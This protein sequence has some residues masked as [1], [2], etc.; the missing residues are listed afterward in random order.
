MS[1]KSMRNSL[2]VAVL[3][4]IYLAPI[5]LSGQGIRLKADSIAVP[6]HNTDT[7]LMPIRLFDFQNIAGLQ[8]TFGWT[9]ANLKYVHLRDIHPA[10][11]G[12]GFDTTTFIPQGRFTFSWTTLDG[13]S[14][15]D[16]TVLLSV[17]FVRLAGSATSTPFLKTPTD[18]VAFAA[19]F[20]EVPVNTTAGKVTPLDSLPPYIE[21]PAS[22]TLEAFGPT[23]VNNIGIDSIFDNCSLENIGWSTAGATMGSHPNDPDASGDIFNLGV[24]TVTYMV[25]DV[26]GNTATCSFTITINLAP[27]DSLTLVASQHTSTCGQKVTVNI[28]VLNFDSISG[29]QFSLG[30]N[31]ALLKLDT[32]VNAHPSMALTSNNFGFAQANNGFLG[33]A[34]TS[35]LP[36]GLTLPN[37]TVLFSL[38]FT[39]VAPTN[40]NTPI[41][42][43]DFPTMQTAFT[44]AVLPPEEIGFLT[45]HGNV[46]IE[47]KEPPTLACPANVSISTPPG[48]LTHTFNNLAPTVLTDNCSA[49]V[50]L[51]YVRAGTT[52][53]SDNG[54]AD[55]TYNAGTTVVTY[56]ATDG[57]GNT[58][59]CSFT[60]VVDAGTPL[61]LILDTV[62]IDCQDSTAKFAIDVSVRDFVDIS[63]LQ[64]DIM[65]DSARIKFD[66]VGNL[67]PGFNLSATNFFGFTSAINGN[68]LK[69]FAG[70]ASGYPDIPDDEALFTI[71]FRVKTLGSSPLTYTGTINAVNKSFNLIPVALVHG[72]VNISDLSPPIIT[73]PADMTVSADSGMCTKTLVLVA[74]ASDAC[75][76]VE[77]VLPDKTND[78]YSPGPTVVVFTATDNA[79]N[80][81]TC[82]V[83]ITVSGQ[84]TP[85]LVNCPKDITLNADAT[86]CTVEAFWDVPQAINPCDGSP[87][88]VTE[89]VP[90]GS[91][92]PLGAS[93][94]TFKAGSGADTSACS[95]VITVVDAT[96]P[97]LTCP[98][99]LTFTI[100][101]DSLGQSGCTTAA[102]FTIP[103][104]SDVCDSNPSV[105]SSVAPGS[106]LDAGITTVQLTATDASGNTTSCQF[107]ITV[108]DANPPTAQGCPSGTIT[109]YAAKDSCGATAN[110][111]SVV[112]TDDCS[113][114]VTVSPPNYTFAF[115]PIGTHPVN[116]VGTDAGGNTAVCSFEVVVLDTFAPVISNC[117]GN[118]TIILPVDSCSQQVFWALPTVTDNCTQGLTLDSPLAPGTIF[119][120]GTY[121]VQYTA[122]DGS[123][124]VALCVFTIS[125]LDIVPPKFTSCPPDLTVSPASPCGNIV[126]WDFP[127]ATDNCTLDTV[128]ATKQPND[129][130]FA[131]V[132]NVVIRALDASG[133]A[134][135]CSFT[136]TLD[137]LI[138]PPAFANFPPDITVYG[139]PQPVSWTPPISNGKACNPDTIVFSPNIVPGDTF[140]Q[141]TTAI[142]YYLLDKIKG[143]T[144]AQ[145]Q[146]RITVQDT[147][148]PVFINCP[149]GPI[150]VHVGGQIVSGN[151]GNFITKVDT[152][153][154]CKGVK[155]TFVLPNASDNCQVPVVSQIQG[156]NPGDVFNTGATTLL[157]FSATDSSG[158]SALCSVNI[159]V[160]GLEP[161]VVT[162]D[163]IIAC[164]GEEVNLMTI[165]LPNATYTWTGP[166]QQSYPNNSQ[167]TVIASAMTAGNYTVSAQINGCPSAP[168][169]V[170]V[171]VATVK[172]NADTIR[173]PL[174]ATADTFSVVLND[175]IIPDTAFYVIP[176]DPLP[177]GL[178]HLG[179]GIFRF[180]VPPN[181][182]PV[183]FF[184]ELCSS[185]CDTCSRI[186]V[187]TIRL[188]ETECSAIPN[189]FSPNGDGVNDY[190]RIPCIATGLYPDNLVVIYN[191]WG[192]KVFESSPYNN[193]WKGTLN[194]QD[195]KNLP[196]GVYYYI[197]RPAPSEPVRKG[198]IQIHR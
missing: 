148:Q 161:L 85:Q 159:S 119:N 176:S 13:L 100:M 168:A 39:V 142:N 56:T 49:A 11:T 172:A 19:N 109:L 10:F 127:T 158:N 157:G 55:G 34:W 113:S 94:V 163:P 71:Y 89:S 30:W 25:K 84:T 152:T 31:P 8:F 196:D 174:G 177:E 197:F 124:N 9:P 162:V 171:K 72:L 190:F 41:T 129:T 42:F 133:N 123:G 52:P 57:A 7:F 53:G 23:A 5:Q 95:F 17:A 181:F 134:D 36:I 183:S 77:S 137:V 189:I 20:D 82:S 144:L 44:S 47:D 63:G 187:V 45:I 151:T 87:L 86:S 107:L 165:P 147:V 103:T 140:P 178:V 136:I 122:T 35:P 194:G 143:D 4:A 3:F 108:V 29:L 74:T 180:Q 2:L 27:S 26:G 43:G 193:D 111:S 93:T 192:D 184:Y 164:P 141:G 135:T 61:T 12:V 78:V 175:I 132:T 146:L 32:I 16:S 73:C 138:I 155:L 88:P 114:T 1:D 40:G 59:T 186:E 58:S 191:Q 91:S 153:G 54:P 173:I 65:W 92:F 81:A 75:S 51:S 131:Q 15:P 121:S 79:G 80:T 38:Q 185:I 60:V 166:G 104:A 22:L 130:I 33:F 66:S 110:W 125:V 120:T 198:F 139:C 170:E 18:I 98:P 117:P 188:E 97:T 68:T 112:F 115:F 14:L 116:I 37:G 118:I 169:T 149:T 106:P 179:K 46:I 67:R 128:I 195:G 156:P 21:C 182:R 83:T 105:L 99:N 160:V 102:D 145:R 48:I 24:S 96:P 90:S 6:C 101:P 69:F 154:D 126:P 167:I 28:S 76:G 70:N 50:Q 150:V 62:A 64:F